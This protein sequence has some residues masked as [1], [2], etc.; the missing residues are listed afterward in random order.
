[1]ILS[2]FVLLFFFLQPP[3]DIKPTFTGA[4]QH[5]VSAP[6]K[7]SSL[8]KDGSLVFLDF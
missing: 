5:P 8:F 2:F 1:M 3:T 4:M 6:L 7:T